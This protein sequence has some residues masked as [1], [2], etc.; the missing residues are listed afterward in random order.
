MKY[1]ENFIKKKVNGI[2]ILTKI[3]NIQQQLDLAFLLSQ[4]EIITILF[5][6]LFKNIWQ[7]VNFM[8]K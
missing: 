7:L 4:Q 3:M 1:K 6:N 2:F 8:N 5:I